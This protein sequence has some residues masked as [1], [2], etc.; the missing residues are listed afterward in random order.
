[1]RI[2]LLLASIVLLLTACTTTEAPGQSSSE[3]EAPTSAIAALETHPAD[4]ELVTGQLVYVPAYSDIYTSGDGR[5]T[6]LAITLSVNNTDL[7]HSI[8]VTDIRYYNTEG[9]LVRTYLDQPLQLAPMASHHVVIDPRD[10]QGGVGANFLVEWGAETLVHEPVIEA[11]MV[12]TANQQGLS[13]I[14]LGRVVSETGVL[15]GE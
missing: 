9:N 14:S 5:T 10:E 15:E 4:L 7:E 1:M 8:I 3:T 6:D 12:N 2:A 13:L 11:V